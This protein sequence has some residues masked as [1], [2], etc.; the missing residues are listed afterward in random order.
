M[1]TENKVSDQL[2]QGSAEIEKKDT[3]AF[4][5]YSK[6]LS[7]KKTR[8]KE[9]AEYKAQLESI[10]QKELAAQGK[11]KEINDTLKK[12]LAEK[13]GKL[14]SMF[15]EFG[16]KTLK[17]KFELEAKSAGCVDPD[18]LYK[19][20]DLAAVEIGEDFN[21]D[22]EQL[23]TVLSESQKARPYLF[24]KDVVQTKDATPNAGNKAGAG[25]INVNK[26]NHDDLKKLLALKL[27]KN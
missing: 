9:V 13:D 20:V 2:D 8:D 24:K 17:S 3:V 1:S 14:K 4:A 26:M 19:L 18:A 15:Q 10:A 21:F 23:K 11:F 6:L 27:V 22:Q 12:Q 5:T 25:E 16:S 7:E